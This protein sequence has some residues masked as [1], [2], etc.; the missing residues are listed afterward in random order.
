MYLEYH[1]K[2]ARDNLQVP[3]IICMDEFHRTGNNPAVTDQVM[4]DGREGRKFNVDLRIASQLIEDFPKPIIEIA[5]GLIVCN[6][7]SESSINYMDEMFHLSANEKSVIRYN[8]HGPGPGGAP[9][10]ALFRLKGE[11]QVRQE[12]NLTLGPAELWAFSTTAQDVVLRSRL[13]ESIGPKR[14]RQV[15]ATRFPGGSARS[16]IEV[17]IARLEDQGER[18]DDS[19]RGDVIG[20][21]VEELKQQSY[22]L[23]RESPVLQCGDESARHSRDFHIPA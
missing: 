10:W 16:D 22:K 7:G 23:Q 18:L 20:M 19:G 2:R 6:A 8:L 12:L 11:G 5:S 1:V 17:R 14:A 15:L 13:Y 21:I 3:K 9:L 4:Q